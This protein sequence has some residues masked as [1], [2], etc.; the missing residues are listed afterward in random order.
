MW[1]TDNL[2]KISAS[3]GLSYENKMIPDGGTVEDGINTL[4]AATAKGEPVPIV[5]GNGS[6]DYAHYVLVTASD[7][8]PPRYYKIHDPWSGETVT[9]SEKQMRDGELDIAG[10]LNQ[11]EAFAKPTPVQVGVSP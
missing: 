10:G 3:T 11:L 1:V 6:K 8:G 9:R 2:N 7:P 5:I 4:N